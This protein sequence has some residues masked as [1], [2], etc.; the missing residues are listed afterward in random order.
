MT[1]EIDDDRN[2]LV[3]CCL[4]PIATRAEL[5]LDDLVLYMSFDDVQGNK[6]MDGSEH[7]NHGTIVKASLAKGQREIRQRDGIQRRR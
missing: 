6:V 2:C 3:L 4:L 5:P 7:G 1:N